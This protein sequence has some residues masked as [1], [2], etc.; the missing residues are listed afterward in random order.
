MPPH[1][2]YNMI[3]LYHIINKIS[4]LKNNIF[5]CFYC[6]RPQIHIPFPKQHLQSFY[7]VSPHLKLSCHFL[8]SNLIQSYLQVQ[9]GVPLHSQ[10]LLQNK[11]LYIIFLRIQIY[12]CKAFYK[13]CAYVT[14]KVMIYGI[15]L[16]KTVLILYKEGFP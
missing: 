10:G 15:Y 1:L 13:P 5:T 4:N 16:V 14:P 11:A 9:R 2:S 8:F 7:Q 3:L 6:I 12:T